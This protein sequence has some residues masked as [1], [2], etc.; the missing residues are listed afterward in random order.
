M[1]RILWSRKE[2]G[3]FR[4]FHRLDICHF[5]PCIK[6]FKNEIHKFKTV[7]VIV[8]GLFLLCKKVFLSDL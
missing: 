6:K 7:S 3:Y 4:I 5:L 2:S 1:D 8:E